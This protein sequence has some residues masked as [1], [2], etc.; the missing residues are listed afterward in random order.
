MNTLADKLPKSLNLSV[1]NLTHLNKTLPPVV[2][3]IIIIACSYTLAQITWSLIPADVSKSAPRNAKTKNKAK[4]PT[5]SYKIITDAHLFGSFKQD[6]VASKATVAPKTRLNLALKGIL[7]STPIGF[8]SAIISKG[9]NGKED[10][11]R[12]GDKIASATI[13]EIYPDRVIIENR[14]RLETL[15]MPK[16]K[17]GEIFKSVPSRPSKATRPTTPGAVLSDI[18]KQILKNPTSFGK[19]AIPVPVNVNGKLQGYRLQPQGDRRLFD[20]LGLDTSDVIVAING[21]GLD[22][23]AKGL[24]ALRTLQKAKSIELTVLRNGAKI[25]LHFDIP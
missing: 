11:Y 2:L 24:K 7:A 12:P 22:D 18:R 5:P 9:K 4:R 16:D 15:R 23:P 19:F 17:G 3:V 25:P 21:V 14:G 8:G 13:K 1:E 6:K 10:T 20:S